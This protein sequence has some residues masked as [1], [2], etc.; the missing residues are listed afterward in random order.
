[1]MSSKNEDTIKVSIIDEDAVFMN[2][3]HHTLANIDVD[4]SRLEI[5]TFSD[6][7]AFLDDEWH[8]SKQPQIVLLNDFLPKKSGLEV[9]QAL[10]KLPENNNYSIIMM[11]QGISEDDIIY[12]Y[13][14]GIDFHLV[15]PFNLRIFRARLERMVE[16]I[17]K[18]E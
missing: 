14:S 9:I 16:R 5:K 10:R 2:V 17:L 1:M 12:A 4:G 13:R 11:T 7:L 6:G 3:L 8:L 15:K 18:N